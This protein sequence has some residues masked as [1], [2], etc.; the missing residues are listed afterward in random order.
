MSLGLSSARL[1]GRVRVSS[2]A[3]MSLS[4]PV[5]TALREPGRQNTKVALARP[6]RQR[7]CRVEVP[8]SW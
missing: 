8:M 5:A 6:A 2:W 4:Q 1:Q 7:D 3:S